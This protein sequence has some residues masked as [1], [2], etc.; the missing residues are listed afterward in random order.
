MFVCVFVAVS[1]ATAELTGLEARPGYSL[2]LLQL[3]SLP[4]TDIQL[5]QS[6]AI[7][8]KNFVLHRWNFDATGAADGTTDPITLSD[9]GTIKTHLIS[10]MVSQPRI[11]QSQLGQALAIISSHDFP[12]KWSNLLPE[13]VSRLNA[14][15]VD[16]KP[17]QL[18]GVLEVMHSIF[19]RY[20]IEVKSERL[21]QELKI[22]LETVCD[23]LS[24]LFLKWS[25]NTHSNGRGSLQRSNTRVKLT[26]V[27]DCSHSTFVIFL[28]L[29]FFSLPLCVLLGVLACLILPWRPI[30]LR[31]RLWFRL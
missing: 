20:R 17:E 14:P 22:V 18:V 30:P 2:C 4:A 5:K 11:V 9:R 23:P 26:C 7:Q 8:F 3:I 10:L 19:Y 15:D 12:A 28:L 24:A 13:L 16:A 27:G 1:P 21:W 29:C 31:C 25:D 6:A